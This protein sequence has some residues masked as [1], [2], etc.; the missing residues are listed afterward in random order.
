MA[1]EQRPTQQSSNDP[2]IFKMVD[3]ER[4]CGGIQ[5]SITFSAFYE[6]VSSPTVTFSRTAGP[7]RSS[8]RS[9]S[10]GAGAVTRTL[11]KETRRWRMQSRGARSYGYRTT[12][13]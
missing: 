8:T 10:S 3:P 4:Y 9:T 7:T 11:L 2:T 6:E 1:A 13:R 12:L 5:N